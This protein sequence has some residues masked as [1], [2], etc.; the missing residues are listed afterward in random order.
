VQ[1]K[2]RQKAAL[3][4][5]LKRRKTKKVKEK[6]TELKVKREEAAGAFRE[7]QNQVRR[8][9]L[10]D[11]AEKVIEVVAEVARRQ[12]LTS[13]HG[14]EPESA[15][16]VGG[17]GEID[18]SVTAARGDGSAPRRSSGVAEYFQ[19]ND[20]D[21]GEGSYG[22]DESEV[23]ERL[24]AIEKSLQGDKKA[25]ASYIDERDARWTLS[26]AAPVAVD[27]MNIDAEKFLVYR[28]G[29][30]VTEEL[31]GVLSF[32]A[33]DLA[34]AST[35]PAPSATL[36]NDYGRN[37]F[38]RSYCFDRAGRTL[39]L[40]VDRLDSMGE[41]A[42]VLIHALA[43][44]M[45]G[46]MEDDNHPKFIEH[47]HRALQ[48]C[49][50]AG[51]LSRGP[52]KLGFSDTAEQ[53]RLAK[54][55]EDRGFTGMKTTAE[56]IAL[57]DELWNASGAP[58]PAPKKSVGAR[59]SATAS[60]PPIEEAA[61]PEEPEEVELTEDEI[62]EQKFTTVVLQINNAWEMLDTP[63]EERDARYYA[64][65]L[66]EKQPEQRSRRESVI[67]AS[68]AVT[69]HVTSE[70]VSDA[71]SYYGGLQTQLANSGDMKKFVEKKLAELRGVW[72]QLDHPAAARDAF[73]ASLEQGDDKRALD[74]IGRE[75]VQ[76]QFQL[77]HDNDI[78]K[79]IKER[80]G[81]I[82]KWLEFEVRAN[83][84]NRFKGNS[85]RLLQEDKFRKSAYPRLVRKEATLIAALAEFRSLHHVS[86]AYGGEKNYLAV[87]RHKI[88][89]RPP[90][91]PGEA[92]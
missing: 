84:P 5:R 29:L 85:M 43:H 83:D 28:T 1:K 41:C 88:A 6:A 4:E 48:L 52:G 17:G 75:L 47:F 63:A 10:A 12:S 86:F 36:E 20:F 18:A 62:N 68:G 67:D 7:E 61:E 59:A 37:A 32:P 11:E 46:V 80:I 87:L 22:M 9:M 51:L 54:T 78:L 27:A 69:T 74:L 49:C 24:L 14:G 79:K 31:R 35:L 33:V 77:A 23:Y 73:M 70:M 81:F 66:E 76:L 58:P 71:E 90:N 2:I 72:D 44:I 60:A 30:L 25:G 82:A 42:I 19:Q 40:R 92:I 34:L 39:H 8:D 53:K 13:I 57:V 45:A 55:L 65:V 21:G 16:D 15:A 56:R 38:R 64:D 26:G 91:T 3:E 89:L 50:Q